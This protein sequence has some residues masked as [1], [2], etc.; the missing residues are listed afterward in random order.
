[1]C[2]L[3]GWVVFGRDGMP[4]ADLAELK[5]ML[6]SMACRGPDASASWTGPGTA[7]GHTRLAIVDQAG[8]RQ[9]M[10]DQ[11][12]SSGPGAV[13]VFTGE[14]YNHNELRREL[15]ARGHRFRTRSDTEVVLAAVR[16]WGAGAAE[17]LEGIF[18]FAVWDPRGRRL[19]LA[20]DRLGV[21]PLFYALTPRG[22]RFGSEPKAVLAH[23]QAETILDLP[24]LRELILSSH[25]MVN[26][27]GRTA[28][29]GLGEV[30]PAHVV[31]I[32]AAGR[33]TVRRYWSLTPRQHT[34]DLPDTIA[35]VRDLLAQAVGGQAV[36]EVP[37]CTLLSGGLDSS[38][39][40][41]LARQTTRLPLTTVSLDLT[42]KTRPSARDAMRRDDDAPYIVLMAEALGSRHHH[43]T[44][45][46]LRL[47]D[48]ALRSEVVRARDGL[49][50]GDF[51]HSA[52]LLFKAVRA[53]GKVA[54]S[55]D[56]SDELFGGYRWFETEDAPPGGAPQAAFPW[57]RVI[58]RADLTQLLAPPLR[59]AL[60]LDAHRAQLLAEARAEL[61]HLPSAGAAERRLRTI[62]H[63]S[64]TR[65][66][67]ALLERTDRLSMSCGLEV[68]VPFLDHRLVEYVFNTPWPFKTHDGREK[69]LLRA[70]CRGL[71]P[72]PVL[73]RRKSPYPVSRDPAYRQALTVQTRLLLDS[74]SPAVDL[75]DTAAVRDLLLDADTAHRFPREGLEFVLDLDVWLRTHR[76]TLNL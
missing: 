26:S 74:D 54:L 19:L 13:L 11:T 48:P 15:T 64:L 73:D 3:A 32:D 43:I 67:P 46:S 16:Q 76:P 21:K 53:H 38:A 27:P 30:P 42:A 66:L 50:L 17:R 68:R 22:V 28:F 12:A 31:T 8:G 5:P 57:E 41:A 18:A 7:V 55:G 33:A 29:S 10:V 23:P 20:R 37:S 2:G 62:S 44:P 49:S 24:G 6:E 45:D 52:L 36:T 75:L 72:D 70:A 47:A 35:T 25:P 65:F 14:V 4:E 40:A 61:D 69:S 1:M 59:A 56:G 58:T 71:V 51:D 60:G 9:P 39:I 34:D 63:L